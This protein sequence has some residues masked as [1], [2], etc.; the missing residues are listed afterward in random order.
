[1]SFD[2]EYQKKSLGIILRDL[3]S[4]KKDELSRSLLRLAFLVDEGVINEDEFNKDIASLPDEI[5]NILKRK[6]IQQPSHIKPNFLLSI[7]QALEEYYNIKDYDVD[8]W[9]HYMSGSYNENN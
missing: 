6:A 3:N 5:L 2:K 8:K 1:M 4:Y 7:T 9:V